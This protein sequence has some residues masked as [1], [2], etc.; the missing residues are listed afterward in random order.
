MKVNCFHS[1]LAVSCGT[2]RYLAATVANL[3][4]RPLDPP[5]EK[6]NDRI[7]AIFEDLASYFCIILGDK[8]YNYA[9]STQSTLH[10]DS[11][12]RL[13]RRRTR[14][15]SSASLPRAAT[16]AADLRAELFLT[17]IRNR[18]KTQKMKENASKKTFSRTTTDRGR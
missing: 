15:R 3:H 12:P 4:G 10:S 8:A 13:P 7:H 14:A 17:R 16:R 18:M 5:A 2:L 11:A 6:G 1:R 9:F